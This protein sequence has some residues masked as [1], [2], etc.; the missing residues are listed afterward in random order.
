MC[1]AVRSRELRGVDGR[2]LYIGTFNFDPRSENLNTE[3][4]IVVHDEALARTVESA[5]E[6]D[7]R[8]GNSWSAARDDPDEHAPLGKRARVRLWQFAPIRPLL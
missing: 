8:P 7:M 2:S 6:T 5:I 3:V 4:G 1:V